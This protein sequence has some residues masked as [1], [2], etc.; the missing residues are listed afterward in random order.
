M[1][2]IKNLIQHSNWLCLWLLQ[3]HGYPIYMRVL[4]RWGLEL[5]WDW[6]FRVGGG[7]GFLGCSVPALAAEPKHGLISPRFLALFHLCPV[8]SFG[9]LQTW[10]LEVIIIRR[11]CRYQLLSRS[12]V[13]HPGSI[14]LLFPS[15]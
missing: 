12:I 8:L 2:K 10:K 14:S 4:A 11:V 7:L 15:F 5:R 13:T 6:L 9:H 1:G 3:P